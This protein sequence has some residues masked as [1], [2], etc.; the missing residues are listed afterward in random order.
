MGL[1]EISF[2]LPNRPGALARVARLLAENRINLAAISVEAT[3]RRGTVRLIVSDPTRAVRLLGKAGY[4]P[5]TGELL[6]VHLEERTGSL[7]QVLDCLAEAKIN[8][9]FVTLLVQREGARVLVALGV[10]N[11]K[12]ALEAL[13][14][15]GYYSTGASGI[16]SNSDL[17]AAAPAIP[18]ESV[19]LLL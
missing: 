19:G 3:S 8:I 9:S 11:T 1:L 10:S 5:T 7:L 2:R 16:V 13:R 18:S 14:K 12:R 4:E 15:A 6:P 17:V